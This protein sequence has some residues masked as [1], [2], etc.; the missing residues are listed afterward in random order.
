MMQKLSGRI[1][2]ERGHLTVRI[3]Q[4]L[5][6]I[7]I[8]AIEEILP[9]LRIE[10]VAGIPD[11]IQGMV[12]VR[13]HLIP[14]FNLAPILQLSVPENLDPHLICLR[15]HGRII[16]MEV[17]EAIDLVDL[18]EEGR[19]SV[20]ELVGQTGLISAVIDH[21]G[22]LIRILNPDH[23]LH[24]DALKVLDS[25]SIGGHRTQLDY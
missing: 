14:V 22:E 8:A 6:A 1:G 7:P 10:R 5:H 2:I 3:G 17:D 19:I 20:P 4:V 13:G 18:P 16:G 24:P 21:H 23:I 12:F 15:V 9:A 11:W 25:P